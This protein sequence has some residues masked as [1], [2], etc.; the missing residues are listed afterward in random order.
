MMIYKKQINMTLNESYE[1]YLNHFK[2]N[3]WT[4][5][6]TQNNL[7]KNFV[8]YEEYNLEEYKNKLITDDNFNEKWSQG[9]TKSITTEECY[10]LYPQLKRIKEQK[11]IH[12]RAQE[13]VK[14]NECKNEELYL[15]QTLPKR[16]I[17]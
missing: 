10:E 15:I 7:K 16:V 3:R 5:E 17:I 8:D 14:A 11:H 13:F 2:N 12:I 6:D 4:T 1:A 9:C